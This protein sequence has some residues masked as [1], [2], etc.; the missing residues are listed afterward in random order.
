ME[1]VSGGRRRIDRVLDEGF[2]SD[3]GDLSLESLR[4][5]RNLA[6]QEEADLSYV[7]RMLQGRIEIVQAELEA[8]SE[9]GEG[10]LVEKLTQILSSPGGSV[11]AG[12]RVTAAPTSAGEDR[13]YAERLLNAV[14][15]SQESDA[16]SER[17]QQVLVKLREEERSVSEFRAKVQSVISVL[18]MELGQRY[19][20]GEAAPPT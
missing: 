17:G 19:R 9:G 20:S 12:A 14:G 18:T 7:R 4:E 1:F 16:T 5:R 15:L 2:V 8:Y 6:R 13:R 10:N 11:P 3:I